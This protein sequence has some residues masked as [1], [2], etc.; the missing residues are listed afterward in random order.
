M[1]YLLTSLAGIALPA[2]CAAQVALLP[3]GACNPVL[4]QQ[5]RRTLWG[6]N[7]QVCPD[8]YVSLP[9]FD[10]FANNPNGY[11]PRC[12]HWQDN[13]A[14]INNHMCYNPPTLGVA[15]LD[16]LDPNGRPYNKLLATSNAS[17]AD[18]L[19]SQFMDLSGYNT[20][21]NVVLSFFA[22]PQGL[23]DR[24]EFRDS[25]FLEFKDASGDWVRMLSLPGVQ[26]NVSSLELIPFA[27]Y[28]IS[29]NQTQF[30][31]NQFQ[32]RFRNLASIAG[33]NDHW[34]LDYVYLDANR[35]VSGAVTYPDI[36]F[37]Q[38][39]TSPLKRYTAMPW[40]HVH[41]GV[42]SDSIK[43]HTYNH[44]NQSGTMDRQYRVYDSNPNNPA[45]ELLLMALPA[46]TYAPSPNA[47]DLRAGGITGS[48]QTPVLDSST[49]IESRYVLLNPLDFQSNPLFRPS[50]TAYRHTHLHNYFAY[51]DGTAETRIIAQNIGTQIAVRFKAEVADT[52]R[53]IYIH[54]P[55]YVNRDAELDFINVKVWLD[56]LFV[57]EEDYSRDIYR[58]RYVDGHNGFHFVELVD[59]M[60]E[61]TPLGLEAGQTFYV[62]WQQA[63]NVPVPIG[64]DRSTDAS[65]N[66]FVSAGGAPWAP[67]DIALKGAIMIRPLLSLDPDYH[68]VPVRQE[69]TPLN[70]LSFRIFPNPSQERLYIQALGTWS[71]TRSLRM[72]VYTLLG[73][74]LLSQPFA[75]ELSV[76]DLPEGCYL[77]HLFDARGRSFRERFVVRR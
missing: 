3:L 51:D 5:E 42:W 52:L 34:H 55:H 12:S 57:D 37:T 46:V 26:P 35:N 44:S 76:G 69:P 74:K 28:F 38:E 66:T 24:P 45:P 56:T 73:Q 72:E 32:F 39:P 36:A 68:V 50:D 63:S 41:A 59:F 58:L 18:T 23:S 19:T 22:Q 7:Q 11:Y 14:F 6:R 70:E 62:G 65:A 67:I 16:G 13:H 29:V 15:T 8:A 64:Y 9:F 21:D 43:V 61:K 54:L 20:G 17:P 2:L 53:G 33:A 25:L 49:V 77:L 10:D 60:G 40:R 4:E 27:Q 48:I 47:N 1:K 31:H 75:E 30:L 71:D